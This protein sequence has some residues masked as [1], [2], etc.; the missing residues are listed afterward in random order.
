M[1]R[2]V[3]ALVGALGLFGTQAAAQSVTYYV[4]STPYSTLANATACPA[5]DCSAVYT[6]QQRLTGTITFFATLDPDLN[7]QTDDVG[8]M[9]EDF[10]LSDGQN[11]YTL[12]EPDGFTLTPNMVINF[13]NVSTDSNGVVTDFEFKF[14]RT[15]GSPYNTSAA[16]SNDVQ[17]RVSSIYFTSVS[18]IASVESNARCLSRGA[19]STA[20]PGANAAGCIQTTV[21]ASEGASY[22]QADSVTMSLTPPAVAAVPTLTEWAMIL[23]GLMLAGA[24]VLSIQRRRMA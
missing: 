6:P 18:P 21:S 14:D 7:V 23:F 20:T 19:V 2:L 11:T 10:S 5:G 15:N 24:A 4:D 9:I 1:K 8:Y 22:A 12:V 3:A 17:T 13:A 16:P